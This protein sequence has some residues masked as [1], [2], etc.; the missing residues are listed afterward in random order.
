VRLEQKAMKDP[1]VLQAHKELQAQLVLQV[2][3]VLKGMTDQLVRQVL[4]ALKVMKVL[5]VQ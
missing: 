4:K 1:Q 5:K 3:K 2:P